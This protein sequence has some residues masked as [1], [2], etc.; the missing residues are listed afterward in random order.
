MTV[1]LVSIVV[2]VYNAEKYLTDC[3]CSL[4]NQTLR[5][6][7]VLLIDDGSTDAS[8]V[9]CRS[10][11][12][13]DGRIK[14]FTQKN[15]G[16][17][18]ARNRALD[19]AVG[20]WVMFVDSDDYLETDCIERLLEAAASGA[21]IVLGGYGAF[22]EGSDDLKFIVPDHTEM[23][24]LPSKALSKILYQDGLDIAPW[25]KLFL[26]TLFE[27][28]RFP[29]LRSSEDLA[30]I[31]KPFLKA[32]SVALILDSGYRYRL[33]AGSLSYSRHESEAWEVMRV[34]SEEIVACFPELELPC[35]CRRLS[36]AF[37]VFLISDD[38]AVSKKTWDE[39]VSTRT[40]VL[41]DRTARKKARIAAAFSF[42]GRRGVRAIGSL[43]RF[44]R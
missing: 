20:K 3:L 30:T 26:R 12:E 21:D 5:D 6:F 38:P 23:A 31:Y 32:H 10:Y 15:A 2:P 39:I 4:V 42:I 19:E 44:S 1:P 13:H 11:A 36:F 14:V 9:I 16:A 7:E 41:T 43:L 28:V 40:T 35:N 18:A 17:A 37:H 29:P 34:A 8:L 22:A 27:D 24:L 33:V 25:G